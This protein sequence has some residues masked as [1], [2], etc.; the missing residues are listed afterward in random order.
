MDGK[1]FLQYKSKQKAWDKSKDVVAF[2]IPVVCQIG[3]KLLGSLWHKLEYI[4]ERKQGPTVG[5]L[6]SIW[7][8]GHNP[9]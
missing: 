2:D 4:K 8:L 6:L 7:R 5:Q 3:G 1:L 9:L